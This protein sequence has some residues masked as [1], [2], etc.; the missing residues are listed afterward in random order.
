MHD[1]LHADLE[2]LLDFFLKQREN[3]PK[4][5]THAAGLLSAPTFFTVEK[6]QAHA[7]NP[8]LGP[9]WISVVRG[10]QAVSLE[11]A[12]M[13]KMVQRKK[14]LFMDKGIVNSELDRGA[15]LVLEGIDIL[16]PGIGVFITR[17]EEA[18]PCSLCNS[19]AFFSQRDNEAYT[20]HCDS[21]DVL[22]VQLSGKKL[23]NIYAPQ[24]RRYENTT[25]LTAEQLGPKIK[26][27]T[28]QP[29]DALYVRA[30]VPHAC[31]TTGSHSLHLAFDLID[32]TPNVRQITEKANELYDHA[33]E[34]PF[35]LPSQVMD[36]YVKLL[37]SEDF[38]RFI[39]D[40]TPEMKQDIRKFRRCISRATAV[41][42]MSK[43]F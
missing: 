10:G 20:A 33:C 37:K 27:L 22:V 32:S 36:R 41:R 40:S 31:Q 24:Q 30:G 19:V 6:L 15:A 2:T 25:H 43:Y 7:N 14:L 17:L 3:P 18:L 35:A 38:L 28:M 11:Q 9:A 23:W 34:E 21:D 13:F 4:D 8:L 1:S 5:F 39:D 42:A 16:D 26:Q 29:G 12:C